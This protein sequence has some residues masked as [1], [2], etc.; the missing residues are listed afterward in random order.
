MADLD[1]LQ[2]K[3]AEATKYA[4]RILEEKDP[5][6]ILEMAAEMQKKAAELEKMGRAIEAALTPDYGESKE[7]L[8]R[9]TPEQKDRITEQTG[10]GIEEVTLHD[11]KKR[12]WSQDFASGKVEPREVEKEAAKEAA[13]LRAIAETKKNVE[14][15]IKELEKLDVPELKETLD[16]LKRDPT[17]GRHKKK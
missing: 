6:R 2:K 1:E 17:L 12:V 14:H 4:M 10:V 8:V 13:R 16:E 7:V 9:L 15:I 3:Q 11:S 5:Q